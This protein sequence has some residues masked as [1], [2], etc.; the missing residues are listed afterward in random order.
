VFD[1]FIS[2]NRQDPK[3]KLLSDLKADFD[4]AKF[5][6]FLDTEGLTEG[7]GRPVDA[8]IAEELSKSRLIVIAVGPSGLGRYQ[9]LH[10]VPK[11]LELAKAATER[12]DRWPEVVLL[13]LGQL[14]HE[15]ASGMVP[16]ELARPLNYVYP[17]SMDYAGFTQ[18]INKLRETPDRMQASAA[19]PIPQTSD[20]PIGKGSASINPE[21]FKFLAEQ[22][23][24]KGLSLFLGTRWPDRVRPGVFCPEEFAESL[25]KKCALP[26]SAAISPERLASYAQF[27]LPKAKEKDAV[28]ELRMVLSARSP[29]TYTRAAQLLELACA[30]DKLVGDHDREFVIVST[31]QNALIEHELLSHGLSFLVVR[32]EGESCKQT[33]FNVVDNNP[34]KIDSGQKP[35]SD[36][37]SLPED[38]LELIKSC[39]QKHKRDPQLNAWKE[40]K[41]IAKDGDRPPAGPTPDEYN[42]YRSAVYV[43]DDADGDRSAWSAYELGRMI[44]EHTK[45]YSIETRW[46]PGNQG[47][48]VDEEA[49]I[50]WCRNHRIP[51]LVK[52]C[53][54][55]Y[56]ETRIG[57]RIDRFAKIARADF[58]NWLMTAVKETP[59]LFAG[60]SPVEYGFQMLFW[61]ELEHQLKEPGWSNLERIFFHCEFVDDASQK[62]DD[63]LDAELAKRLSKDAEPE[64]MRD[65]KFVA[66]VR[67]SEAIKTLWSIW[68]AMDGNVP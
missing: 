56:D 36:E 19:G 67:P 30:Q 15:D 2:Y 38:V 51:I 41:P 54:C 10:E 12:G 47:A 27:A 1:V 13:R 63:P 59:T 61:R 24:E 6:A 18:L 52:L 31:A 48:G 3:R 7:R 65:L 23:S 20:K 22:I 39:E 17:A 26:S 64:V 66:G 62:T 35:R 16:E 57:M 55:V 40:L 32:V 4:R 45:R 34:L 29:E 33:L 25:K 68:G 28:E 42:Y 5:D 53:G 60:F 37:L 46:N 21:E 9:G 58:P 44:R 49:L 11:A 43:D 50:R 8:Q 14:S